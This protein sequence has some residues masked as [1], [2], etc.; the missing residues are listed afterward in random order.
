MRAVLMSLAVLALANVSMGDDYCD[1]CGDQGLWG[2]HHHAR[3]AAAK[4][5][6]W[7]S[8]CGCNGSYKFPVP[9]LYTYHWP[10]MYS[11]QLMTEYHSP[12]RFPPLKP[13]TDE[14]P[15]E[16]IGG[17][18]RLRPL[19]PASIGTERPVVAQSVSF[20]GHVERMLR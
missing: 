5:A 12:W 9:P 19:K 17:A 13:Y 4:R 3:H 10:G 8:N 15:P 18:N 2:H 7:Y 1:E 14:I 16:V 11:A 20:S 6:E